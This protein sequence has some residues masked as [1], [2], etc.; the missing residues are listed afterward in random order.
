MLRIVGATALFAVVHSLLASNGAKR[1][2][3]RL[4]GQRHQQGLY[5]LGF[6]GQS[7]V[8]SGLL[9]LY[10]RRQPDRLLYRVPPPWSYP[11]RAAQAFCL[12]ATVAAAR[13]AGISHL[14]GW[15]SF[16]AWRQN[17]PLPPEPVAQGPS[18]GPDGTLS[19]SGPFRW[20]RHPLNFWPLL[21]LLL[22]PKMTRN[23]LAFG[24]SA[25][26]YLAAGSAHEEA[27]LRDAHGEQ[28]RDYQQSGI[29]YYVPGTAGIRDA[30]S[31]SPPT[32]RSE[33]T[34]PVPCPSLSST[35]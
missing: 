25:A 35:R 23:R 29:P 12:I 7:V 5:R 19:I 6:V 13:A 15:R 8:T 11:L 3:A 10:I 34:T 24:L 20:S 17:D 28:Y 32:V 27:R 26:A 9:A 14:S 4:V 21:V 22:D 30:P 16:Q 2:T 33:L 1:A 31:L 18:A